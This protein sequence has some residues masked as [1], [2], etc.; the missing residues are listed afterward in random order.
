L[1]IG[2][3]VDEPDGETIA[4]RETDQKLRVAARQGALDRADCL[5]M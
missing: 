5:G 2:G 4:G 3:F 1:E